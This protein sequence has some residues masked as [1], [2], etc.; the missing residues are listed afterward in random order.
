MKKSI[1]ISVLIPILLNACGSPKTKMYHLSFTNKSDN[2]VEFSWL[3]RSTKEGKTEKVKKGDCIDFD[4]WTDENPQKFFPQ[5]A[6]SIVVVLA[7]GK[8]IIEVKK[9]EAL[10]GTSTCSL[11]ERSFFNPKAYIMYKSGWLNKRT[12]GKEYIFTNEDAQRAK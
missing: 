4:F 1:I 11:D 3:Y 7:N 9:C 12:G 8:K 2:T 5:T 6:D 10:G